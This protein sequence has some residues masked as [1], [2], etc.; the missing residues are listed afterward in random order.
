MSDKD[1]S[2]PQYFAMVAEYYYNNDEFDSALQYIEKY[3]AKEPK[4]PLAS[5]M[6]ALVFEKQNKE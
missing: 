5:Q 6:R 2:T 1:K 4:S 3:E